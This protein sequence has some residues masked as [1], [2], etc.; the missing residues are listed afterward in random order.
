M[1]ISELI[2]ILT[3]CEVQICYIEDS[4]GY[5]HEIEIGHKEEAF[6]GFDELYPASITFKM[7]D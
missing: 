6:D 7:K 2:Q 4:D 5:L 3:D 1:D